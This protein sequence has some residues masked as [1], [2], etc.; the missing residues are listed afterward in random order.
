MLTPGPILASIETL[1]STLQRYAREL[2]PEDLPALVGALEAAKA[3]AWARLAVADHG[4]HPERT[5]DTLLDARAMAKRLDVPESW[6]R[7]AARGGRVPCI[8]VGRYMRF[9]PAAV[10]RALS[11]TA[12]APP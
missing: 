8:Y 5:V 4:A 12:P 11:E 3:S 10:R 2:P 1:A 6:L 9:D 7:D